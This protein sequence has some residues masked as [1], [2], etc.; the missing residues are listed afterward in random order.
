MNP[1]LSKEEWLQRYLYIE[2]HE[3]LFFSFPCKLYKWLAELTN[4]Q[5]TWKLD[6]LIVWTPKL[7]KRMEGSENKVVK[8]FNYWIYSIL[9]GFITEFAIDMSSNYNEAKC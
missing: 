9:G 6:N 1:S 5:H 3:V 8:V 7:V 4:G 2:E